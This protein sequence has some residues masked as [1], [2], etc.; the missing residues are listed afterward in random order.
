MPIVAQNKSTGEK[1]ALPEAG[2]TRAVCCGI[3]DLGMQKTTFQGKEKIQHKV[4][5]AWEI[6]EKINSPESEFHGQPY[7]LS[8]K[9]TLSLSDKANLRKDLESWR[10]KPYTETEA[11]AGFDIEKLYGVSCFLGIA[12]QPDRSDPS[13]IYANVTAILPLPKGMEKIKPIREFGAEP[14]MW[15]QEKQAQAVVVKADTEEDPFGD[16]PAEIPGMEA[17]HAGGLPD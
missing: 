13:K 8:K 3:W 9:Y 5:I 7:M 12:H 1:F 6:E 11:Q 10:G 15:V 17:P 2:T 16:Y 14:P 4:I